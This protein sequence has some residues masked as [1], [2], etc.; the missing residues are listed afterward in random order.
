MTLKEHFEKERTM[1]A[2][3]RE[4]RTQLEGEAAVARAAEHYRI[5]GRCARVEIDTL[6]VSLEQLQGD[7][8]LMRVCVDSQI[9]GEVMSAWTGIPVGKMV[10]DEVAMVLKMEAASGPA[11]HRTEPRAGR[12]QRTDSHL[13]REPGRS[14]PAGGRVHAGRAERRREN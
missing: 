2:R 3:I 4:L 6:S 10:K 8:P 1:V 11:R 9:V 12:D 14:E 5:G 7:Q 13:A